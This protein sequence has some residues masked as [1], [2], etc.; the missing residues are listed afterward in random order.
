MRSRE[1]HKCSRAL[2]AFHRHSGMFQV[3]RGFKGV[4]RSFKCVPDAFQKV[5]WTL[6]EV[7][8]TSGGVSAGFRRVP[9]VDKDF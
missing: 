1:F 2:E 4:S 9:G 8:G 3:S 6:H 7:L 5:L